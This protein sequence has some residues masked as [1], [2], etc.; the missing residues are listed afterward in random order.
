MKWKTAHCLAA[1]SL[2]ANVLLFLISTYSLRSVDLGFTNISD[3]CVRKLV[4][5]SPRLEWIGIG[6][7]SKVTAR[8]LE[9]IAANLPLLEGIDLC[10]WSSSSC[11][12][13]WT[14]TYSIGRDQLLKL[15][16]LRHVTLSPRQTA[17]RRFIES[18]RPDVKIRNPS[19]WGYVFP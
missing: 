5:G 2:L 13:D 3:D 7:Y 11:A 1:I 12:K 18:R 19:H 14:S 4:L 17:L 6:Y 10:V 15:P 16:R 9:H 8:S